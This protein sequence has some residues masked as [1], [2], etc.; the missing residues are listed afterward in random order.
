[1][2]LIGN[3]LIVKWPFLNIW[4]KDLDQFGSGLDH[5]YGKITGPAS[6]YIM[7]YKAGN[8]T[9]KYNRNSYLIQRNYKK[10]QRF[11]AGWIYTFDC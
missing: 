5:D 11:F 2:L 10:K 3:Q 6:I 9:A 7:H 8:T 1:V 4:I